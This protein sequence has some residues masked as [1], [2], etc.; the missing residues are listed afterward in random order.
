MAVNLQNWVFLVP[1]VHELRFGDLKGNPEQIVGMV[2]HS[3]IQLQHKA[4]CFRVCVA[5]VEVY[6]Y[7]LIHLTSTNS[8]KMD[9]LRQIVKMKPAEDIAEFSV[10]YDGLILVSSAK[11]DEAVSAMRRFY[12]IN[13]DTLEEGAA[14]I[15]TLSCNRFVLSGN[16]FDTQRILLTAADNANPKLVCFIYNRGGFR[17]ALECRVLLCDSEKDANLLSRCLNSVSKNCSFWYKRLTF[18]LLLNN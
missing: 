18:F 10:K 14:V 13:R 4:T 15:S 9:I 7:L 2:G 3:S 8:H 11:K 16:Y 1:T 5:T 17:R 12:K 6:L